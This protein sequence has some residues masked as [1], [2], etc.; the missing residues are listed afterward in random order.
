MKSLFRLIKDN[1]WK[2]QLEKHMQQTKKQGRAQTTSKNEKNGVQTIAKDRWEK[3]LFSKDKFTYFYKRNSNNNSSIYLKD[4]R[5]VI[6][7]GKV[8]EVFSIF[9][10]L[11]RKH[12][13]G[14]QSDKNVFLIPSVSVK[15]QLKNHFCY[16]S[17]SG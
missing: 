7:D 2:G 8:T 4:S 9:S 12:D 10:I 11:R 3:S 1:C 5:I 15:C 17:K 13:N 14:L 6:S 16:I